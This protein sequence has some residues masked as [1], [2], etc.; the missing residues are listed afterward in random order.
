[1]GKL[2]QKIGYGF[3]DFSSSMFWK[4]F[5]YYLPFF[6][7]NVYGLR[8]EDT[9]MLLLIT[10][11][12]DAISDP[13]MGIIADRTST[14]WGKYRPYL[15]WIAL[16]FA[17]VGI[18]TFTTPEYAYTGKLIWAYATYILMMTVYTAIN[19]PYGAMLA[20]VSKDSKERT[21]YSA[22][23]MFFAYGGSFVALAIFE[24][25][26]D[27]FG[28][29]MGVANPANDPTSWQYA[30]VVVSAICLIFFVLTF[31]MTKENVKIKQSATKGSIRKDLK[32]LAGNK[33]WW[34]LLAATIAV[35]IFNSIRGGVAAYFFAD[36]VGQSGVLGEF[37]GYNIVLSAAIFLSI[38]EIA[39]MLGVI[40]A[41]PLSKRIGKRGA[42]IAAVIFSGVLSLA[43]WFY[44]GTTTTDYWMMLLLQVLI[45]VGAGV[46]LPLIWSMFADVADY[47]EL[48]NGRSSVGLIFSSSSMAQKFGGALG[49]Y[50]VMW[51]LVIYGYETPENGVIATQSA[52]TLDGLLAL[53]SWIPGLACLI[54]AAIMALYPLN[55]RRMKEITSKLN[56]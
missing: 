44:G 51:L 45:S 50:L 55:Q 54:G 39:N 33:P 52:S 32:A 3:G 2:S 14:R 4:I 13:M 17:V 41:V 26:R 10:K 15:L 29:S 8:L 36:Y 6:Y 19:V 12:W 31:L 23:R 38:G 7:S 25:I 56:R 21:T 40:I 20:V 11:L 1:M 27:M 49:G 47:S 28:S 24:P 18:L 48:R 37:F 53:M 5:I 35:L 42:Y 30:M 9:A 22:F 34:I 43:F 46:T 16:P